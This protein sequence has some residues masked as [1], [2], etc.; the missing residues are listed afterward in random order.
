MDDRGVFRTTIAI[1]TP[2]RPG[3]RRSLPE[4]LVDTGSV[5]AAAA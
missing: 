3:A 2:E 4:T 1:E 5:I